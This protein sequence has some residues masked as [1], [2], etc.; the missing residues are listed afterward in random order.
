[1]PRRPRQHDKAPALMEMIEREV[2]NVVAALGLYSRRALA[3]VD[4]SAQS[5][6][7]RSR[8]SQARGAT[9]VDSLGSRE[10]R[11]MAAGQPDRRLARMAAIAR[12]DVDA[13]SAGV[14]AL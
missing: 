11:A 6:A 1:M 8:R 13:G 3:P 12:H 4:R 2:A 5:G 14:A 9:R 10:R 7:A